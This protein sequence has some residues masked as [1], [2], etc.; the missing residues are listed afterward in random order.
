MKKI[1]IKITFKIK[2][3]VQVTIGGADC[4][5][6]YS[7]SSEIWCTLGVK[8][9]GNYT[10]LLRVDPYGF[11][12]KNFGFKYDL[13]ITSLSTEQGNLINFNILH[14]NTDELTR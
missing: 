5:V 8:S 1:L 3:L 2:D 7:N 10:I 14:L 11:A 13:E 6:Q 9:A 4:Q 12:N